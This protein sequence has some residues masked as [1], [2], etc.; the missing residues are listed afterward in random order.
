[1]RLSPR[2]THRRSGGQSEWLGGERTRCVCSCSPTS[3]VFVSRP[4]WFSPPLKDVFSWATGLSGFWADV[5]P[6]SAIISLPRRPGP[7]VRGENRVSG[8]CKTGCLVPALWFLG[9]KRI[10]GHMAPLSSCQPSSCQQLIPGSR[11]A[12]KG[13]NDRKIEGRNIWCGAVQWRGGRL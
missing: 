8:S 12:K 3:V 10:W 2:G 9:S 6:H 7:E 1:M 4:A 13:R 11:W 5:L